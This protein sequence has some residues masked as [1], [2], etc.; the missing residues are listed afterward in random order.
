YSVSTISFSP[1]YLFFFFLMIPLP[2][3]STLFPYTTL[4]RSI[5][6]GID[7]LRF[8][9]GDRARFR[10]ETAAAPLAWP[11]D[12]FLIGTVGHLAAHKGFDLFLEAAASA[13]REIPLARFVVVGEGEEERD[14]RRRAAALGLG[15]RLWFTG[16]RNDIPDVL[17]GINLFLPATRGQV[18]PLTSL[19]RGATAGL[20][21]STAPTSFGQDTI[22]KP[23]N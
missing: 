13:A 21:V 5:H 12:S 2:P 18:R 1:L 11:A 19:S 20:A 16:F 7:P 15:D 22:K 17:A 14:L 23:R 3:I 8:Q 4:F 9:G 10:A 6:S